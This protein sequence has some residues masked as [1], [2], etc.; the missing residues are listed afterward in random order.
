MSLQYFQK[1]KK[2]HI[3]QPSTDTNQCEKEPEDEAP[4]TPQSSEPINTQEILDNLEKDIN[5]GK[6]ELLFNHLDQNLQVKD[7]RRIF[8]QLRNPDICPDVFF[9]KYGITVSEFTVGYVI[10]MR[11]RYRKAVDE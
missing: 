5:L 11:K 2:D 10:N 8:S 6:Y 1:G 9:P 7:V 3:S 4:S